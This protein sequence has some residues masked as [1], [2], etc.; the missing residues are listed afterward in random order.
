MPFSHS[1]LDLPHSVETGEMDF[2]I[3]SSTIQSKTAAAFLKQRFIFH[4]ASCQMKFLDQ[5][6]SI[7]FSTLP[8]NET[9]ITM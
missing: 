6:I 7:F 2:K 8:S 3:N 9:Q 1:S 4:F 5:F